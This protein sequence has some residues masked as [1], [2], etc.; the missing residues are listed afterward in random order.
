M[1]VMRKR[2]ERDLFSL[3][4]KSKESINL[5]E[6]VELFHL[7]C[8]DSIPR[9]RT[10]NTRNASTKFGYL[11]LLNLSPENGAFRIEPIEQ[12]S[13]LVDKQREQG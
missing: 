9:C 10:Y 3:T 2:N 12:R 13:A 1:T 6:V 4:E 11:S 5:F 7:R 8:V